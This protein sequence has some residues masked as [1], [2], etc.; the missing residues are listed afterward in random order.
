ME[1]G[2]IY[3]DLTDYIRNKKSVI[4]VWQYLIGVSEGQ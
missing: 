2:D 3:L 1:I 4:G